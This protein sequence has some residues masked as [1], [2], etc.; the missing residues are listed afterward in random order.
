MRAVS[1]AMVE[2][3]EDQRTLDCLDGQADQRA[4]RG[5][6]RECGLLGRTGADRSMRAPSGVRM[7]STPISGPVASRTARWIVFSSSRTLPGKRVRASS[8]AA[9]VEIGRKGRPFASANFRA[10]CSDRTAT[11]AGRSRSG[12]IFRFRTLRR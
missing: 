5:L 6:G 10:K 12:G 2:R 7:A 1:E 11:S 4:G 3:V 9:S 8:R